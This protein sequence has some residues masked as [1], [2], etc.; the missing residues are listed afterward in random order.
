M[1][2]LR[3]HWN[4]LAIN[5]LSADRLITPVRLLFLCPAFKANLAASGPLGIPSWTVSK[6]SI[7]TMLWHYM[8]YP[9]HTFQADFPLFIFSPE[10]GSGRSSRA[11]FRICNDLCH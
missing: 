10:A 5:I 8:G 11:S 9:P 7:E 6:P 2:F 3:L 1:E 4:P